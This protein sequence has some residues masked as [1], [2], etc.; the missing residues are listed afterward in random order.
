MRTFHNVEHRHAICLK[1]GERVFTFLSKLVFVTKTSI[2][3]TQS[4]EVKFY[5]VVIY[6][7]IIQHI[8]VIRSASQ[9]NAAFK[10]SLN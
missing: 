5:I 7:V 2:C 3:Y 1:F 6:A 9:R 8:L 10:K 4:R